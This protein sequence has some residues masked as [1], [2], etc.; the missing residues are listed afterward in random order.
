MSRP[1]PSWLRLS[2]VCLLV[3]QVAVP[4]FSVLPPPVVFAAEGI[5][6]PDVTGV[7]PAFG[8]F[9]PVPFAAAPVALGRGLAPVSP[10]LT[11]TSTQELSR[12]IA[13]AT[14]QLTLTLTVEP[15]AVEPGDVVTYT[16][17]ATNAGALPLTNLVLSDTLAAGLVYVARSAAGFAYF[18][19][20]DTLLLGVAELVP[21]GVITGSFG[22][23]VQ[24]VARGATI[25]NTTVAT[26]DELPAAVTAQAT[27]PVHLPAAD[28]AWIGPAGGVLAGLTGRVLVAFPADAVAEPVLVEIAAAPVGVRLEPQLIEA[29]QLTATDQAGRTVAQFARPVQVLLNLGQYAEAL[30]S[31]QGSLSLYWLDETSGTWAI[32]PTEVDWGYGVATAAVAHFSVYAAGTSSTLSYGAQHLPTVHGFVTDDWSGNSSVSYPLALPPGPGGL[33]LN[34]SLS[35]SSEGVNSIRAGASISGTSTDESRAKTFDRQAS[36]V[37]WGW[38]LNGLGQITVKLPEAQRYYLGF[39][40]GSFELKYAATNGWQTEPQSFLRI[41]HSQD[42]LNSDPWYVWA[43]D[44]TRYTFGS[45]GGWGN[46]E[47][48]VRNTGSCGPHALAMHLTEVQDTHGN[49]VAV[50]Y[51]TTETEYIKCADNSSQPYMRAIRPTR[52]EYFAVTDPLATVRVDLIYGQLNA[53][54]P[55]RADTGVSG[56]GDYGEAFWSDY[57]LTSITV[58]VRNG[59]ATDAFATVRSYTLDNDHYQ[60]KDQ[61]TGQGLL[62]LMGVVEQGRDGGALPA[63]SFSYTMPKGSEWL[64]H[65]LLATADNGQG[66][67]VTFTY[68]EA[69]NIYIGLC[70]G[71]TTRYRVSQMEVADGQGSQAHNVTRSVFNHQQPFA[72]ANSG[73]NPLCAKDFEFGG[74]GF[75]R[76]EV[77]DGSDALYQVTDNY[78]HQ[79][80][81]GTPPQACKPNDPNRNEAMDPRKGKSYLSVTSSQPGSGELARVET[82]WLTQTISATNWVFMSAV[83]NTVTQGAWLPQR[84]EYLYDTSRQGGRQY[85]NVTHVRE[86]SDGGAT[87][88]RTRERWYYPNNVAGSTYLVNRL[89]QEKLWQGNVGGSCQAETRTWYDTNTAYNQPP[90]RGDPTRVQAAQT[91]CGASWSETLYTYDAWGNRTTAT[92]PRGNTTTTAYD[93][94]GNWPKLY[95]YPLTVTAPLVGNTIYAWDKVLGQVTAVTDPNN[96]TTSYTY[97]EWSRPAK[98]IRSGD[99]ANNP[100]VRYAYTNYG[101]ATAPYWVK[102]EQRDN[103]SGGAAT[104]LETRAFYDGLGRVVQTQAEA[105]SSSQSILANT[106][107]NPLGVSQASVPY[108]ITQP[109][110][111]YRTPDWSVKTQYAYDAL[112]RTTVITYTDGTTVTTAYQGR[113][114]TVLDALSHQTVTEADA[115]GRLISSTQYTGTAG[116]PGLAVYATAV[117]TYNVRDQLTQVTANNLTTQLSY[118]TLGRKTQMT[119][120][121]MGPW[122]YTYD[123]AGNLLTQSD[124]RNCVTSFGYDSLNRLTGKS[125]SGP[126]ACAGTPAVTFTYDQ[127]TNGKGRRTAMAYGSGYATTWRYDARGRPISE[128]QT[129]A[130]A[131]YTTL[132]GYDA[133][134]RLQTLTYPGGE[135]VTTAYSSLGLAASLVGANVYVPA[136]LYDAAGRV[137]SRTLGSG[138]AQWQTQYSYYAWTTP[139]GQGR[140]QQL[141]SGTLA[142][143]GQLQDLSYTYDAVGNVRTIVDAVNSNQRQ[144]FQYDPLDRLTRATTSADPTQLCTT[145]A[146]AGNYSEGY[147]YYKG[148]SLRRKGA[149]DNAADGLYT[150]DANHPHAVATYRGNSY[151]YDANGNM[152]GRV[153]SGVTYA[154]TYNAE[155]RLT[156]VVSGTLTASYVYDGDGNRVRSVITAGAAVTETHYVGQHYEKTVGSGDTKYYFIAGQL[157]AFERSSGYGVDWGRRFVFRDH[158]GSTNVIINAA[159]GLLL[160]RDRYLPFGDVRDT[161]RKDNNPS[162]SLQTAY[163]FTGQRLEQRLGTPE[164]GLDRGLYFYGSRWYDSSLGRFIQADTIVPQPGNPQA[165]NRYS[166]V[167]NNALRYTDPTGHAQVC[168]DGDVGGGCG[169]GANYAEVYEYFRQ[170]NSPFFEYYAAQ[171]QLAEAIQAGASQA[172]IEAIQGTVEAAYQRG[173]WWVSQADFSPW[174][175]AVDPGSAYRLGAAFTGA[176]IKATAGFIGQAVGMAENWSNYVPAK[177]RASVSKAFAGTPTVETL[178]EDLLVYRHWGDEAPEAGSPWFSPKPYVRPGNARRYLA[179]PEYNS[180]SNVSV[181]KIRAGTTI[182]RGKVASQVGQANFGSYAVGGGA[183]IYLPNPSDAVLLGPL[184][185]T[186]P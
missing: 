1:L 111:G 155:N 35:Y 117:Y 137:I 114:A 65:T 79:C 129:I 85:G 149:A 31:R 126:G 140:L 51:D 29:F 50:T 123:A 87:L 12:P 5:T 11:R 90:T 125:Y 66:G 75:V 173:S 152:T 122:S 128:T 86:Y 77:R 69:N 2:L 178:T 170:A 118:D 119:D 105:A 147:D 6:A 96:A 131:A 62:L 141:R 41:E 110:G 58:Q 182:V 49:K 161:Y 16:V 15:A 180:A 134:D 43:P 169:R 7:Q 21:G 138:T 38:S 99:D 81:A 183:Q 8:A 44:G 3:F 136:T 30:R 39:G 127:G 100:T 13:K 130:N 144:C 45:S 113:Q 154:L 19:Q 143:P 64:N 153:V 172:V 124:A 46:G 165:L 104:Y 70:S 9:S 166:Y 177:Y 139:N 168:A 167:L 151:S 157:V 174:M 112:G 93:M 61:A 4:C 181:F 107:Y 98:V 23:R 162:F 120:P 56:K 24:G 10:L 34:L 116:G 28:R 52:I 184:T 91:T 54:P 95:A 97:D 185:V 26:A 17:V 109:L 160:W 71:N 82:M 73:D 22:A 121:N 76:Q 175:A 164:S 36:F 74:Y 32:V 80:G 102:T 53:P 37:G 60:W 89:A 106:R 158:L 150:Y 103:A 176:G 63:W 25:V 18:P 146:G 88:A 133:A 115:F 42:G 135:V 27:T 159:S 186:A 68:G 83:T 108:T 78:Y 48:W 33:G 156:Q 67:R 84:T 142:Q 40:G 101:G 132:S 145:P 72:W 59:T 20:D 179:L 171:V 92:D 163:R 14:G 57:R 47:H 55:N 148:G 94:S